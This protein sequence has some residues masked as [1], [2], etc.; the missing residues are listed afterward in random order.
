MGGL[1]AHT[2]GEVEGDLARGVSRPT[3]K[4]KVEGDLAR[5]VSRPTPRGVCSRGVWSQG[6]VWRPPRMATAVG[7][8]HPTGMHSCIR[9][10]LFVRTFQLMQS[11]KMSMQTFIELFSPHKS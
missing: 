5:G 4:G 9:C 3:P 2:Q 10:E 1:Q 11:Q 8:T 7:S 6:G